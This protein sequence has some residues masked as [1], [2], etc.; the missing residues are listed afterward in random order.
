MDLTFGHPV[1]HRKGVRTHPC[2]RRAVD[3]AVYPGQCHRPTCAQGGHQAGPADR[4][5]KTELGL[6]RRCAQITRHSRSQPPA[7]DR[8]HH[9]VGVTAQL[10]QHLDR[11]RGLA[12]DHIGIVE[13]RQEVRAFF[14]AKVLRGGQ[15]LVEIVAGQDGLHIGAAK[16]SGL[17]DLLLRRGD[18]HE[19]RPAHPEMA[20]GIG[21]PLRMVPR[22]GADKVLLAGVLRQVLAHR[23]QRPP[24]FVAA[25]RRQILTLEPYFGTVAGREVVIE[26]Q[27]RRR[28]QLAQGK[29]GADRRLMEG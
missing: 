5:D 8:Q 3:K 2:H 19:D 27:G 26:L 25:N 4:L 28:K 21:Y 18:R 20:A 1:Q 23:G 29:G 14:T 6:R 7:A 16:D 15:G 17:V 22:T 11:D 10:L 12:F 24:Q 9:K 13:R